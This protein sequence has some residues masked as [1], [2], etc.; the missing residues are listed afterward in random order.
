MLIK[1]LLFKIVLMP[2]KFYVDLKLESD[3]LKVF[4]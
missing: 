3:G 2:E 1:M 4:G